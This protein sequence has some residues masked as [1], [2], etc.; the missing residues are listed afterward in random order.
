MRHQ[1]KPVAD[2]WCRTNGYQTSVGD[3]TITKNA[4]TVSGMM[5]G[6]INKNPSA[7][8]ITAINCV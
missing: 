4:A 5:G 1:Q 2:A 8:V 6:G 3:P 7:D